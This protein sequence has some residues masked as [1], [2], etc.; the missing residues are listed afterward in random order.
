MKKITA[1]LCIIII[2]M[3]GSSQASFEKKEVKKKVTIIRVRNEVGTIILQ[4]EV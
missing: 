4:T 3:S 1:I 2:G